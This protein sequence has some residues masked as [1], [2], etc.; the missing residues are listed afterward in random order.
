M[1]GWL[2]AIMVLK[3]ALSGSQAKPPAL[4]EVIEL[5]LRILVIV[6]CL[7]MAIWNIS[8]ELKSFLFDQT[9][10]ASQKQD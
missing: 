1:T 8:R 10:G 3:T 7:L 9:G 4:A 6:I 5:E 2:P